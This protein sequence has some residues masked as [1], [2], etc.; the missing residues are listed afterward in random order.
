MVKLTMPNFAFQTRDGASAFGRMGEA[1]KG[2]ISATS[3]KRGRE[4]FGSQ[5]Q[6]RAC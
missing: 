1:E 4:S 6:A 2:R 5:S 3:P